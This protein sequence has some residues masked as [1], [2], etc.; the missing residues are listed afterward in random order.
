[1]TTR[2]VEINPVAAITALADLL[3]A[4]SNVRTSLVQQG[5]P[6]EDASSC[7]LVGIANAVIS[8]TATTRDER[9]ESLASA[10]GTVLYEMSAGRRDVHPAHLKLVQ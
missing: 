5:I 3:E 10:L 9:I 6:E 2:Q 8:K 4:L 7:C 1:M